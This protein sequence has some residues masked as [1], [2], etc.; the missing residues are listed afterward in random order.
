MKIV[1][2]TSGVDGIDT[3]CNALGVSRASY[4]RSRQPR[5]FGPRRQMRC[6]RSLLPE[7]RRA[8]LE[9]FHE[10]RFADLA[11][12][13]VYATLLDEGRYLCSERTMYRVLAANH[14][15]RER[16]A[17]LH[18]SAIRGTRARGLSR[19][20]G[21]FHAIV[22]QANERLGTSRHAVLLH[23]CLSGRRDPFRLRRKP[24]RTD[25]CAC[26]LAVHHHHRPDKRDPRSN[27]TGGY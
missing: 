25:R 21:P 16:R 3:T 1:D 18:A 2:E 7:E 12:A 24:G 27:D 4:Y 9:L 20:T 6:P 26:G 15:V 17:Q 11:P 13:Q 8:V 10:D 5:M 14:E 19:G 23:E 22:K